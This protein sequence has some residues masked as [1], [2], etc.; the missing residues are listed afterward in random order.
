[1]VEEPLF[2]I[3]FGVIYGFVTTVISYLSASK[4][5]YMMGGEKR[6]T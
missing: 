4:V 5:F 6:P 3:G 2:L 1:M